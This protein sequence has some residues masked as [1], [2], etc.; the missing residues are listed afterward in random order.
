MTISVT[1]VTVGNDRD[2]VYA[3]TWETMVYP[4]TGEAVELPHFEDRSIQVQGTFGSGGTCVLRGSND[5]TNYHTLKDPQGN[6]IS[7]TAAGIKQVQEITRYVYPEVTAGNG[8]TDLDVT[9]L[10]RR[11]LR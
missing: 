3:K 7:F 11:G 8:S 6:S 1:T 2:R 10:F 9:M 4:S 5:G